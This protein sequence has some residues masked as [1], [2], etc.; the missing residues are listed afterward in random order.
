MGKDKKSSSNK[1]HHKRKDRKHK[2]ERSKKEHYLRK[3]KDSKQLKAKEDEESRYIL[4]DLQ[5]NKLIKILRD[6]I[7]YKSEA[8]EEIPEVFGIL[9]SNNEVD[10]TD[11]EDGVIRESLEKIFLILS[12]QIIKTEDNDGRYL[13]SK[14][15][16]KSLK[17]QIENF[18]LKAK[19]PLNVDHVSDLLSSKLENEVFSMKEPKNINEIDKN[20][21]ATIRKEIYEHDQAKRQK[22]L[23]EIHLEKN[24][25]MKNS[26]GL[27][28]YIYG[29]KSLQKRFSPGKFLN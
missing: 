17:V 18:F 15:G 21:E 22:S 2:E 7:N 8:Y 4:D 9:D 12:K 23:M 5:Y 13:Y 20:R 26:G 25:N 27:E 1:K 29:H 28:K 6:L 24:P 16:N 19:N 14:S 10:I 3:E 11:L